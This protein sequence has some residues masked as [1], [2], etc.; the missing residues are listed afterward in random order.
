VNAV[1]TGTIFDGAN[2]TDTNFE[3]AVIG[4][5]KSEIQSVPR[6]HMESAIR[7]TMWIA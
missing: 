3:D 7:C 1:I 2:L 4:E 5:W 6:V